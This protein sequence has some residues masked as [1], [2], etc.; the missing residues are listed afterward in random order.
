MS[1]RYRILSAEAIATQGTALQV[2]MLVSKILILK[3]LPVCIL[4]K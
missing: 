1:C 3:S 4:F 2:L